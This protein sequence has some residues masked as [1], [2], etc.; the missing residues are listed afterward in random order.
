VYNFLR[1]INRRKVYNFLLRL[2][3]SNKHSTF[4]T[5]M[6]RLTIPLR[7]KVYTFLNR[8]KVYNFLRPINREEGV[9]LPPP[10][11]LL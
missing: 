3:Y 7:M 5:L 6:Y 8:R 1:P 11:R 2:G 9:Q 10:V 4:F